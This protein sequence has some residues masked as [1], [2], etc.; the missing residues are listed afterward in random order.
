[1]RSSHHAPE[2]YDCPFCRIAAGDAL[3]EP[4]TQQRDVV[5]RNRLATAFVANKWWPHN[6][7]HVLVVPNPHLENLYEMPSDVASAIHQAARWVALAMQ[8]TYA[9]EG[10]STRQ[11]NEPDGG[12]EVWHYHLHVFPRYRGDNLYSH[13]GSVTRSE[14]RVAYAQK[15]R[16]WIER[17]QQSVVIRPLRPDDTPPWDLWLTA[18]PSRELVEGYVNRG[19]SF[20]AEQ[21]DGVIVG[22]SVLM[23]TRP[24]TIELVNLAVAEPCQGLGL[25]KRLVEHAIATARE[26]RFR[27]IEVGTGNPSV[28]Q[29]GLYQRC[30]FR[31]VGVDLDFFTRHYPE[32]IY[33]NGLWCRDMIRLSLDLSSK[34][35]S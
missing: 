13:D 21:D 31:I 19:H 24:G 26:W 10:I 34:G 1:M 18:D 3:P 8:E 35:A 17:Q 28:T 12:Q 30:G 6:R 20:V 9:C 22:T 5:Y 29:L 15:L 11:H 16:G 4:A 7:G 25:G 14:D 27:T 2:G 33:E 32:P 23:E